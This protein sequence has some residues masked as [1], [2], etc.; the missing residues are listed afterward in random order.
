[1]SIIN[2]QFNTHF[3]NTLINMAVDKYSCV[4]HMYHYYYCNNPKQ[5]QIL[6]STSKV[7]HAQRK[8]KTD[9]HIVLNVTFL[10]N[11]DTL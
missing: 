10:G 5:W 11:T 8:A 7:L 3:F 6:S 1:M 9:G 4:I 2:L